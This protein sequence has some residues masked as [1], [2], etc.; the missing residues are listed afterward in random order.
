MRS[1]L[2]HWQYA[3]HGDQADASR[4]FP[5]QAPDL[6]LTQGL[7]RDEDALTWIYP[8]PLTFTHVLNETVVSSGMSIR[9]RRGCSYVE[10]MPGAVVSESLADADRAGSSRRSFGGP[11]GAIP[12]RTS[13][14]HRAIAGTSRVWWRRH[15]APPR[16]LAS[17]PR[18]KRG[19]CRLLVVVRCC[20]YAADNSSTVRP[21][22]AS[23]R[24][25]TSP[26]TLL[27]VEAPAV[28][29]IRTAPAGSQSA[30][31]VSSWAPTG[32]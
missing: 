14:R 29:P 19:Y 16:E 15:D 27:G 9:F 8:R 5:C 7:S 6:T 12:T 24:L 22:S 10:E 26:T 18:G 13:P 28:S 2:D 32:R 30:V 3:Y 23:S 11:G 4:V 20:R 17:G 21:L 1:V 31:V 25:T